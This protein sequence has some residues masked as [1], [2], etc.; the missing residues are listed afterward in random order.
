MLRGNEG[1]GPL[2]GSGIGSAFPGGW[3]WGPLTLAEPGILGLFYT[4]FRQ[5]SA[6]GYR[7]DCSPG[8]QGPALKF[9]SL[10]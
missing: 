9:P 1:S 6:V 3:I 10:T 5:A 2:S 8:S 4:E 7:G